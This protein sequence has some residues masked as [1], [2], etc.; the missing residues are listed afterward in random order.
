MDELAVYDVPLTVVTLGAKG[1]YIAVGGESV[2]IPAMNV[3]AVDT[4]GAGDAFVSGM[5]YGL[6]RF[7]KDLDELTLEEAVRM[8]NSVPCP[9][10]WP[11][12][13]KAPCKRCRHSQK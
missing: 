6:C 5:L 9:V 12:P 1:S 11:L 3:T 8:A 2:H 7:E 4:T 10:R 13:Q